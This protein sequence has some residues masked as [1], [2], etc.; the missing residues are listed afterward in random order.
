MC[1]CCFFPINK[2]HTAM[3]LLFA[4]FSQLCCDVSQ[5]RK[6]FFLVLTA[7]VT[8]P[9]DGEQILFCHLCHVTPVLP[10]ALVYNIKQYQLPPPSRIIIQVHYSN[11]TLLIPHLCSSQQKIQ[12]LSHKQHFCQTTWHI[13]AAIYI[14]NRLSIQHVLG[15]EHKLFVQHIFNL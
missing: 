4:F 7:A 14:W 6:S 13:F 11:K 5:L 3:I 12:P 15:R 2:R 8:L 1:L 9:S 10:L